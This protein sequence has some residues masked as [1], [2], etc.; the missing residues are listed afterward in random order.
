MVSFWRYTKWLEL[1]ILPAFSHS[2]AKYLK[3]SMFIKNITRVF[4]SFALILLFSASLILTI[5]SNTLLATSATAYAN[6]N[7]PLG[8]N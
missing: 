7:S 3:L 6:S 2:S 8:I 4:K 5:T 1:S